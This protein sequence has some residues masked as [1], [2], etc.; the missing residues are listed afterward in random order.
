[1]KNVPMQNF[2]EIRQGLG[3]AD[4]IHNVHNLSPFSA[5]SVTFI[6]IQTY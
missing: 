6:H 4:R 2:K 3:V 1:M 5:K